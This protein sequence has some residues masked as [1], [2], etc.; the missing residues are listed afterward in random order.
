VFLAYYNSYILL[1]SSSPS[2]DPIE[3]AVDCGYD[4]G[5]G[6]RLFDQLANEMAE[7]FVEISSVSARRL[8]NALEVGFRGTSLAKK[9]ER[10]PPLSPIQSIYTPAL[11]GELIANRVTVDRQT[12][13][14]PRSGVTLRL[15]EF[16]TGQKEEFRTRLYKLG[17]E[18][19][20]TM[21][22]LNHKSDND[23]IFTNR[24]NPMKAFV[25]WLR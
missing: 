11:P 23:R 3:G 24:Q 7:R 18:S 5:Y 14:C 19:N 13:A 2:A 10:L 21:Q 15:L 4:P 6:P 25:N 20:E 8:Y 22:R 17:Q 12:G 1:V 16:T 9:T